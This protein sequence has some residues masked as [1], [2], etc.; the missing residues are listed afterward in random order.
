M[1]LRPT[2]V[3][4]KRHLC[5]ACDAAEN[6][7]SNCGSDTLTKALTRWSGSNSDLYWDVDGWRDS[8]AYICGDVGCVVRPEAFVRI[9][10]RSSKITAM[11]ARRCCW[12]WQVHL[13]TSHL[14]PV[15]TSNSVEA[16]LSNATSRT[17]LSTKTNVA[18][19]LLPVSATTLPKTATMSNFV[20]RTIL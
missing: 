2:C 13:N 18:S 10:W 5:Y 14:S 8:V 3:S 1:I 17:I 12:L 20:E 7:E 19:T 4:R 9:T 11:I 15:H 16:T 6:G